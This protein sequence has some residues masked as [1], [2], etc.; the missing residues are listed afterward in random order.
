MCDG[1]DDR[2]NDR[3]SRTCLPYTMETTAPSDADVACGRCGLR[4]VMMERGR[5]R[6]CGD[7]LPLPVAVTTGT[8]GWLPVRMERLQLRAAECMRI[9]DWALHLRCLE[10]LGGL[11]R[12]QRKRVRER[13][14]AAGTTQG[15]TRGTTQGTTHN[16]K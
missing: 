1:C 13:H 2:G 11:T 9:A 7:W 12:G 14:S 8:A 15:T 5:C 4:Q 10:L 6:G 3:D 16:F